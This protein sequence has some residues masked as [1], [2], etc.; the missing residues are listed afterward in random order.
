DPCGHPCPYGQTCDDSTGQC[1]DNPCVSLQC[2]QGQYCNPN[3]HGQCEP[4]PCLGTTC[5]SPDQIC[6]G[7]TCNHQALPDGGIE[8][9]VTVG[10]GGCSTTGGGGGLA[11]VLALLAARRR[12][13]S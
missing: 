1:I 4:D 11:I 12:R 6:L 9:H 5:P 3:D 8:T 10:G 7:G 2:P 13:R